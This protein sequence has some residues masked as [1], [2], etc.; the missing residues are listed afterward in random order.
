MRV[1]RQIV[2][3]T[4]ITTGVLGLARSLVPPLS[5]WLAAVFARRRSLLQSIYWLE[6]CTCRH[7]TTQR[8]YSASLLPRIKCLLHKMVAACH[9]VILLDVTQHLVDAQSTVARMPE[10][11]E[12]SRDSLAGHIR[13]LARDGLVN[14]TVFFAPRQRDRAEHRT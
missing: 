14:W 6:L 11:V 9:R 4:R 8:K 2:A 12:T 10:A 13:P 1:A 5:Y 3:L 7:P